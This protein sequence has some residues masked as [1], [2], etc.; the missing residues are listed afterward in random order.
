MSLLYRYTNTDQSVDVQ[1][2]F[3][4]YDG[5]K[6]LVITEVRGIS[7]EEIRLGFLFE[8]GIQYWHDDFT[9]F[10]EDNQYNL[11]V[12]DSGVFKGSVS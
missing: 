11:D 3:D 2:L 5:H 7:Q 8:V 12:Y 10:A 9:K 1:Y 6:R 4:A